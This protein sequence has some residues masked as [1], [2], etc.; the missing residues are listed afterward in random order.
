MVLVSP[1][2]FVSESARSINLLDSVKEQN[3]HPVLH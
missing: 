1:E 2:F 3:N